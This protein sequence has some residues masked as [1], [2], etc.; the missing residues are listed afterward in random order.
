MHAYIVDDDPILRRSLARSLS[1]AAWLVREFASA[2]EFV[3]A[4]DDLLP[5][6]V[7]LDLQMPGLPGLDALRE[8]AARRPSWPALVIS[9]TADVDDAVRAF[10]GGA[11]HLLRKPFRRDE[12]L[13]TMA[14]ASAEAERRL[15]MERL[16]AAAANVHLSQREAEVL[17]AVARGL[18]SKQI[19][20]ELGISTRTVHLHRG[21]AMKKLGVRNSSQAVAQ[22]RS[23]GLIEQQSLQI[24]A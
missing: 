20:W 14:E 21:N 19:A 5:G 18:Q 6:C 4:I 22:A 24:A 1:R 15:G 17:A 2:T 16:R 11:L 9:G 23:L 12:L 13:A 8:I 3:D 10:R 7:L